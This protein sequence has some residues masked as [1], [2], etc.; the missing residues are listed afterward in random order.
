MLAQR[1]QLMQLPRAS[2]ALFTP[3]RVAALTGMLPAAAARIALCVFCAAQLLA[4][5]CLWRC[6][7]LLRLPLL[8]ALPSSLAMPVLGVRGSL[9]AMM[10]DCALR[11]KHKQGRAK[12]KSIMIR[13]G[14]CFMHTSAKLRQVVCW[15]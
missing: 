11:S 5:L 9:M 8:T 14:N 7:R 3:A 2:C 10:M 13:F 12:H 4:W 1:R 15:G 6:S